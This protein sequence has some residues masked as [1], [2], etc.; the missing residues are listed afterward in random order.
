MPQGPSSGAQFWAEWAKP[1][2]EYLGGFAEAAQAM[3]PQRLVLMDSSASTFSFYWSAGGMIFFEFSARWKACNGKVACA[4]RWVAT[5]MSSIE[6]V[7]S[8]EASGAAIIVHC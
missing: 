3:N 6:G 7:R 1:V 8:A 5:Q 2:G 4:C